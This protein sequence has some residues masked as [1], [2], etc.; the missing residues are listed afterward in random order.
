M[1]VRK[2]LGEKSEFLGTFLTKRSRKRVGGSPV[3]GNGRNQKAGTDGKF[4]GSLL[5]GMVDNDGH[6]SL[7]DREAWNCPQSD[8]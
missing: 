4:P 6:H 3:R 2:K 5:P 1:R 8:H 7:G